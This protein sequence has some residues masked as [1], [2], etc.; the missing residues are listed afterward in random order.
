MTGPK[1]RSPGCTKQQSQPGMV[2]TRELLIVSQ[3]S[4]ILSIPG[5]CSFVRLSSS[6]VLRLHDPPVLPLELLRGKTSAGLKSFS[7]QQ[8]PGA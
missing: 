8:P 3:P 1:A 7:L 2:R 6:F 5:G 4:L